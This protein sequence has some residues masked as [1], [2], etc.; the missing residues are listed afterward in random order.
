MLM[1][2]PAGIDGLTTDD[3]LGAG[4]GGALGYVLWG[5]QALQALS[6]QRT[7]AAPSLSH[8]RIT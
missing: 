5:C 1:A 4:M 3:L 6:V 2:G 8:A 7:G